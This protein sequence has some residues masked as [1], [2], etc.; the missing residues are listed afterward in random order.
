MD[1]EFVILDDVA[2]GINPDKVT[3]RDLEF[4][5][6][7]FFSFLD[8]RYNSK[9]PTVITS[10]LTR[11]Q[12]KQVYSERIFSRLFAK[13]NTIIEIFDDSLDKRAQGL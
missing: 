9:K 6:E 7:V 5:R 11:E 1:D 8:Y 2:S 13:E 4:R 12:F 3:Y 10:N